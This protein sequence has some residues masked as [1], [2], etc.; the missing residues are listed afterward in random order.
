MF[1]E[2]PKAAGQHHRSDLEP[3]DH[4]KS[5]SNTCRK[6][7][8]YFLTLFVVLC[9]GLLVFG[10]VVRPKAPS[11]QMAEVSVKSLN[12]SSDSTGGGGGPSSASLNA[13]LVARITVS[14]PNFGRFEGDNATVRVVYSGALV[15]G[16]KKVGP[17]RVWSRGSKRLEV[18]ISVGAS[19]R[20]V[21]G[22]EVGVNGNFTRDVRLG[23]V[24]LIGQ[25]RLSGMVYLMGSGVKRR[26]TEEMNCE[27]KLN[28]TSRLV[29]DLVCG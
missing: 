17:V 1:P 16:E 19:V 18:A 24:R 8:V 13:T 28:L 2:D 26:K 7:P 23:L 12:Y 29:Q 14:N 5:S 15:L 4:K 21:N 6:L 9:I 11:F 10:I 27:M 3:G 20:V 22:S 25:G